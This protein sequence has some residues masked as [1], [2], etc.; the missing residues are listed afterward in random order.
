MY[1]A[2]LGICDSNSTKFFV[3]WMSNGSPNF[4][5]SFF[6]KRE[7]ATLLGVSQLKLSTSYLVKQYA[8]ATTKKSEGTIKCTR[9]GFLLSEENYVCILRIVA[10]K[11][12][13]LRSLF[14][15]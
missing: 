4:N 2:G 3:H 9:I 1:N 8:G 12:R 15:G 7:Y 13:P 10:W 5:S 6:K 14:A 11:V